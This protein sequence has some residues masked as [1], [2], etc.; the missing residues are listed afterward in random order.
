MTTLDDLISAR[1]ELAKG[2]APGPWFIDHLGKPYVGNR[3]DGRTHG[4][5]ELVHVPSDN[6]ADLTD[7]AQAKQL[8]NSRHIAASDPE[9]IQAVYEV[10]RAAAAL[11]AQT[12][13]NP[14]EAYYDDEDVALH[15]ALDHLEA[16][17]RRQP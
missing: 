14:T 5:W 1:I 2:A 3:G 8:N 16:V 9:S 15:H 6:D 13:Q 4:L 12:W 7:T 11:H 10:A 17:L